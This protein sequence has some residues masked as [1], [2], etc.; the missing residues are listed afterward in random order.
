MI[1]LTP[2]MLAEDPSHGEDTG[3]AIATGT[4]CCTHPGEG[5]GARSGS[6]SDRAVTD[7]GAV[8][9]DHETPPSIQ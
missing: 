2:H 7:D 4:G 8:A 1:G 9:D 6:V 5:R 3:P